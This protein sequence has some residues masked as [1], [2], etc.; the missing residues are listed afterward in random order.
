MRTFAAIAVCLAFSVTYA[1]FALAQEQAPAAS[2]TSPQASATSGDDLHFVSV[3]TLNGEV[4]ALDPSKLLVTIKGAGGSSTLEVR[5]EKELEEVK[6]GDHVVVRYIEGAQVGKGKAA[7][8]AP[9]LKE[10][11]AGAELDGLSAK[12]PLVASVEGVDAVNQEIT[13]RGAEGSLETIE[14]T[15]PAQLR[16]IKVGDKIVITHAEALA[17][18]IEKGS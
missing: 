7:A 14:V 9:S 4:V 5:S 8:A 16:Q 6:P 15:N 13:I 11:I 2:A 17:L 1:P 10:G 12:H 18:S 3:L